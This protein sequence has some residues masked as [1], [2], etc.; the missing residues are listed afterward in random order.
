MA[1]RLPDRWAAIHKIVSAE[2]PEVASGVVELRGAA[3]IPGEGTKL[4]VVSL[5]PDVDPISACV[6]R[7][8]AHAEAIRAALGDERLDI[9]SWSDDPEQLVR[10]ALGPAR[11]KDI[12]LDYAH[13]R[14]AVFVASGNEERV[15]GRNG[16]NQALATELTGWTIEIVVS[17]AA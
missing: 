3:R 11:V 4:A 12:Q 9:L 8:G 15:R 6:G 16:F 17:D 14:A 7:K 1:H 13:H 10:W 2:V 5:T